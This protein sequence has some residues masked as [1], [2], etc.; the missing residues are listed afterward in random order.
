[1][2]GFLDEGVAQIRDEFSLSKYAAEKGL[3]L[4]I[5]LSSTT[6]PEKP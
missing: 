6:T 2:K 1:M 5:D 4:E 3:I